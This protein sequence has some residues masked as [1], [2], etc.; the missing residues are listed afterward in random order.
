VL[1]WA[2]I[3]IDALLHMEPSSINLMNRTQLSLYQVNV[4][5]FVF[6]VIRTLGNR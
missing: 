4:T 5:A 2:R 6:A 1:R 3:P